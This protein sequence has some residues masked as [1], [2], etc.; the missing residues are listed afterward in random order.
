MRTAVLLLVGVLLAGLLGGCQS[1]RSSSSSADGPATGGPPIRVDTIEADGTEKMRAVLTALNE[2]AYEHPM[3]YFHLNGR[4]A[5]V[6]KRRLDTA[7]SRQRMRLRYRYA[8]EL[9]YAGDVEASLQ[10]LNTLIQEA[11]LRLPQVSQQSR[12]IFNLL[13]FAYLRLGEQQNCIK[14]HS[15]GSCILP[16][17]GA[18]VHTDPEGSRNAIQIYRHIARRFPRDLQSRWLL[19][20]AHMTLGQYPDGLSHPRL[21]I[22]GI[23]ADDEGPINQFQDVAGPLGVNHNAIAG[24]V[25]V[26]DFNNDGFLDIFVTSYGLDDEPRFYVNDGEGGFEE[27]TQEAGLKGLVAGLNTVHAD[28]NNDGYEDIFVLRGAW[29][30][31][32]GRRPNSLLRN[33]G[34]GTF[35]DVTYQAGLDAY[36]PTQTAA[37]ADV[38]GDGHIDLFVGNES[39]TAI[40][41]FSGDTT[42]T[43]VSPHPSELYL[44]QGD[45]TF[46]DTA[47]AANLN[48][49]AYVKGSAWGDVN[50]DGWPDLYVSVLGGPNRLFVNQGPG[51]NGVPTFKERGKEAG[52][53]EPIFSFPVWF[54]DYN[55]DGHQDLFVSGFDMRY[56]NRVSHAVAAEFLGESSAETPRVYRNDGDGTFTE[57]SARLNL[58]KVLFTMGANYGDLD[59]DGYQDFYAGTGA[60]SFSSIVPNRMFHNQDGASFEEVSYDGGFAHIQKG[61]S[62]A[63][64]DFDRDGD[65][66]IYSVMGGAIPGDSFQNV[67]FENPGHGHHSV[68]LDLKGTSANRS[69]IG[70]RIA[71]T[72][73]RPDG[74]TRT[75]H[76][77]V[78]TGGSFGAAPLQA[79][80]GLGDAT[81]IDTLRVTWPTADRPTQ[82]LT[83]LDADQAYRISQGASP[84]PLNRS[85]TSFRTSTT[86]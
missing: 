48:V 69:A 46:A 82:T 30:G 1:E 20:I 23:G 6:L 17:R 2:R 26:E 70:A 77:T 47:A 18:G 63:F 12:P 68:T 36:H 35:T 64:A 84:S 11:N 65:Q 52:V 40:D 41:P 61:H 29:L 33:D 22:P 3:D 54:W 13:G 14:N 45:G 21:R 50:N 44:N 8:H 25:N 75:I 57:V 38:N 16:I 39:S 55:N 43:A 19:N 5:E 59:N 83:G 32:Q 74:T 56:F 9:L 73:R 66:D 37:W 78:R 34:D 15:A 27:R 71:V 80:I 86:P 81:Q 53:R 67:L 51:P 58:D 76:R 85:A 62:V 72:A 10:A 60:P 7:S 49:T 31:E 42:N 4:R 28:Y 24:G 79:T